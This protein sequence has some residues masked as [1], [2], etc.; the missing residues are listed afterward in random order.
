MDVIRRSSSLSSSGELTLPPRT[1][2][3]N[4]GS[5]SIGGFDVQQAQPDRASPRDNAG[6]GRP[7]AAV[8]LQQ[9]TWTGHRAHGA[10]QVQ[11][12]TPRTPGGNVQQG[13]PQPGVNAN[14][15]QAPQPTGHTVAASKA[16]IKAFHTSRGK[17]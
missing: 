4:D 17:F 9:R 12:T 13:G 7:T 2:P 16:A 1:Q 15:P 6:P 11:R 3:A 5:G 14:Q 8:P 10:V